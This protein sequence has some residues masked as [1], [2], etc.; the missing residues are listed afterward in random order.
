MEL[1]KELRRN[2]RKGWIQGS[3]E[4]VDGKCLA[5]HLDALVPQEDRKDGSPYHEVLSGILK[6]HPL[7][8]I[9]TSMVKEHLK[10]VLGPNWTNLQLQKASVMFIN[11]KRCMEK[12]DILALL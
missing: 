7:T 5:A 3:A 12:E 9:E 6:K 11:D 2:I 10:M 8:E 4:S 1:L